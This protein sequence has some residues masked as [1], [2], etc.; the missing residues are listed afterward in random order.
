MSKQLKKLSGV[1]ISCAAFA[2]ASAQAGLV[3]GDVNDG[4]VLASAIVG[5]GITISNVSYTGANG[6]SGSFSNGVASGLELES[7]IML[8]TGQVSNAAGSNDDTGAGTDNGAD[9]YAPLTGLAGY[10]TYDAVVLSFDFEFDGGTGGDLFF[11][12]I[13]ASE[14]YLEF[15]NEGVNDVFALYLDGVNIALLPDGSAI[16]IDTVN[17]T[18]NSELFVDNTGGVHDI[19]YDGFTTNMEISALGLSAGVHT[20]LALGWRKRRS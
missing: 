4:N 18:L 19:E 17:S 7:G 15:V 13:F 14:E 20:M 11:D 2:A 5:S 10:D 1:F 16:S 8:T 3:V 6:A 12:F 9:G